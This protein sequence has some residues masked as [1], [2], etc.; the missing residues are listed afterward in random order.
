MRFTI[1]TFDLLCYQGASITVELDL[2]EIGI[3]IHEY[4]EILGRREWENHNGTKSVRVLGPDGNVFQ[5]TAIESVTCSEPARIGP[6]DLPEI[7]PATWSGFINRVVWLDAK[8]VLHHIER[9]PT[10]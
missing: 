2:G 6:H 3:A 4:C 9:N 10:P 7:R 1:Q 8:N 5:I